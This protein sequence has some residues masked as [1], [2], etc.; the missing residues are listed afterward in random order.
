MRTVSLPVINDGRDDNIN[1]SATAELAL[2]HARLRDLQLTV[3]QMHREILHR[4]EEHNKLSLILSRRYDELH[5][6]AVQCYRTPADYHPR[7]FVTLS[8]RAE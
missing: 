7:V 4:E 5:I 2:L 6:N 1:V 8:A 3:S